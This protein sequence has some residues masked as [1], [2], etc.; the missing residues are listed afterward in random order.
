MLYEDEE[1][2][3]KDFFSSVFTDPNDARCK[4][5]LDMFLQQTKYTDPKYPKKKQYNR[6]QTLFFLAPNR[7]N[8]AFVGLERDLNAVKGKLMNPG[9]KGIQAIETGKDP[10][11]TDKNLNLWNDM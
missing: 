8:G 3:I 7:E 6:L 11:A 10:D 5:F 1:S 4:P 9:L 2:F